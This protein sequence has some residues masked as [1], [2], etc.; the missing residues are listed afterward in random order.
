MAS[1]FLLETLPGL[2]GQISCCSCAVES[3]TDALNR[4][5]KRVSFSTGGWSG[6][7][8][9]ID[10]MLSHFWIKQLHCEWRRG[11]HF[12][13]DVPQGTPNV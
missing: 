2:C 6:A 9:L 4:P 12:V 5:I 7:E 3:A 13:F 8:D 11:G 1:R 10:A